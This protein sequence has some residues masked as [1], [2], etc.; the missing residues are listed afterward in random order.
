MELGCVDAVSVRKAPSRNAKTPGVTRLAYFLNMP[1]PDALFRFIRFM[2]ITFLLHTRYCSRR[3]PWPGS[4]GLGGLLAGI[5][6][7]YLLAK[8]SQFVCD[9]FEQSAFMFT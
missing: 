8:R 5:D 2:V 9:G 1:L 6:R 4:R 3:G 7:T